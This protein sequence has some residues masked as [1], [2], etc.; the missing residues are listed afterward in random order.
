M[1]EVKTGNTNARI[2][3]GYGPQESWED[4]DRL[5]FFEALEKE[6]AYAEFEGRSIIISMD[7]NCK[8]GKTYISEDPHAQSKNGKVLS[9]I[10]DRHALIVINGLKDKCSGLITRE[11]STVQ[12]VEQSVIDFVIISSD[13]GKHIEYMHIDDKRINVL[14]KW[15]KTDKKGRK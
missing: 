2:F 3:T 4:R 15:T 7:A 12:G 11:R 8:L 1:V 9:E 13:L 10:I 14:T 5:P 6:I